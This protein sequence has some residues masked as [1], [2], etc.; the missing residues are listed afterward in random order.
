MARADRATWAKRVERWKD[1]GLSAAE[2]AGELGISPNSLSWWKWQLGKRE[3]TSQLTTPKKPAARAGKARRV[4]RP[5]MKFVELP[6]T[7]APSEPLEVVLPSGV[8]VRVPDHFD[9]AALGRLLD[10]LG[11]QR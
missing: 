2:F 9:A 11:Q 10:T 5:R 4:G 6:S 3:A 8:R 7:P 1:S